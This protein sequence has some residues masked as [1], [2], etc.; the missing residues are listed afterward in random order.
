M[1]GTVTP[2]APW[3]E[4][5][6]GL[7]AMPGASVDTTVRAGRGRA[8]SVPPEVVRAVNHAARET[9]RNAVRHGGVRSVEVDLSLRRD[10]VSLRIRDR[11]VGF[12]AD[13][14][15]A[16][17]G[18]QHSIIDAVADVGGRAEISSRPGAGT[19]V[20][21]VWSAGG[22]LADALRLNHAE[23]VVLGWRVLA[24][25]LVPMVA[26]NVLLAG[27][28]LTAHPGPVALWLVLLAALALVGLAAV[29]YRRGPTVAQVLLLGLL[30]PA[31]T[32]VA[33]L[34][35]GPAALATLES[36][37]VGFLAFPLALLAFITPGRLLPLLVG[38][39][40][41]LLLVLVALSPEVGPAGFGALN[42]VLLPA[43]ASW[44]VGSFLRRSA[45]LLLARRQQL[46]E[47]TA[48]TAAERAA[49][50]LRARYFQYAAEDIGPFLQ[51]VGDGRLDPGEPRVRAEAN[52]LVQLARDDL[53]VPGYFGADLRR[54]AQRFRGRGGRLTVAD[55]LPAEAQGRPDGLVLGL[56]LP[57]LAGDAHVSL[58]IDGADRAGGRVVVMPPAPAD[59]QSDL[60]RLCAELGCEVTA[61]EY[62][63]VVR[64]PVPPDPGMP[65]R[66]VPAVD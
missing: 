32:A 36:W 62:Q 21:L 60:E 30:A 10:R 15:R 12:V 56:L 37:Y 51:A 55:G 52:Q 43:L 34:V 66:V 59:L 33:V 31:L 14:A 49:D 41:V 40:A 57:R 27:W 26:G 11:G 45:R 20:S 65:P 2:P 54:A 16:G 5:L 48:Q 8:P 13:G 38:P 1:A 44:A 35:T 53:Y 42:S 17:H 61:T 39:D 29:L 22:R 6:A 25:V 3:A 28:Q 58:R 63:T 46:A 64:L 23:A 19:E 47:V 18:L 24:G 50:R 9:V 4:L 7:Q